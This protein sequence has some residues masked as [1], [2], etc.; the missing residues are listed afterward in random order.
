MT[1]RIH[2]CILWKSS[3]AQ[4]WSLS[5]LLGIINSNFLL[6]FDGTVMTIKPPAL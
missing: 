6:E 3:T 2:I 1:V 4:L 5:H